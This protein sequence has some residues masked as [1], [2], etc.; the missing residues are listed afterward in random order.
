MDQLI[1]ENGWQIV[2][3]ERF[4]MPDTPRI[5]GEMYQGIACAAIT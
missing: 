5:L 3:L 1:R 4:V 2:E